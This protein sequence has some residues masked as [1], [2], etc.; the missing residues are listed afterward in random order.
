[1][2]R[3]ESNIPRDRLNEHQGE[4]NQLPFAALVFG[5]GCGR[6]YLDKDWN[7]RLRLIDSEV[8]LNEGL[9]ENLQNLKYLDLKYVHCEG[10]CEIRPR[11]LSLLKWILESRVGRPLPDLPINLEGEN[12]LPVLELKNW[13]ISNGFLNTLA[14][15]INLRLLSLQDLGGLHRLPRTFG[16]VQSK[17]INIA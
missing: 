1:V 16:V 7:P 14:T 6:L 3:T 12:R 2:Q 4:N 11:K 17:F 8:V 9:V 13:K 10:S 15:L 5:S